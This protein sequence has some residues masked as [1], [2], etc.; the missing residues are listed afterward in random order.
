MCH[1]NV[2]V[3]RPPNILGTCTLLLGLAVACKSPTS[4]ADKVP[5][6]VPTRAE[7]ARSICGTLGAGLHNAEGLTVYCIDPQGI[8]INYGEEKLDMPPMAPTIQLSALAELIKGKKV[9]LFGEAHG[10]SEQASADYKTFLAA[11]PMLKAEGFTHI[12]IEIDKSEHQADIDNFYKTGDES[13]LSPL[14]CKYMNPEEIIAI[15]KSAKAHNLQIACLD[16][17]SAHHFDDKVAFTGACK[18]KEKWR[19][20]EELIY[21]NAQGVLQGGKSRMA[22]FIGAGHI[23]FQGESRFQQGTDEQGFPHMVKLEQPLGNRLY[24]AYS[25]D[26]VAMVNLSKECQEERYVTACIAADK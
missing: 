1:Y 9:V 26:D 23:T 16:A 14:L 12:G 7:V 13:Y 22:I 24:H 5:S 3:M 20:R 6:P 11:M 18:S 21:G 15:I 2:L 25:R 4:E 17:T 8:V 19:K 10:K